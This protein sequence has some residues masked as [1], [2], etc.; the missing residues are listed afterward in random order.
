MR[1]LLV[2]VCV[3]MLASSLAS[4]SDQSNVMAPV[5]QFVDGFNKGDAKAALAACADQV[6]IIDD[7]T[8]Y[9]W[10]GSGACSAW[11]QAYAA[12]AKTN[13]ITDGVVTLGKTRAIEVSGDDAYMVMVAGFIWKEN[14][15]PKRES[16]ATFTVVLHKS[17]SRWLITAWTWSHA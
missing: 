1:K 15:Q 2:V 8:P 14:G 5:H 12:W 6:S 9:H 16:G 13:G 4:A 17:G 7:F 3:V 11:A 10:S